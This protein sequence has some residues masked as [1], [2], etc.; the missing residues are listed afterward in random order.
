MGDE[1]NSKMLYWVFR[2]VEKQLEHMGTYCASLESLMRVNHKIYTTAYEAL[3]ERDEIPFS[4]CIDIPA[5]RVGYIIDSV[6][7]AIYTVL[8]NHE[9]FG[10]DDRDTI[11]VFGLFTAMLIKRKKNV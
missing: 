1:M 2:L 4:E 8:E 6:G 7:R 11:D 9:L 10:F 3:T 5:Q